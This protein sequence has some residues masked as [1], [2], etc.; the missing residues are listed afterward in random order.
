[1]SQKILDTIIK[2]SKENN[3]NAFGWFFV[4]EKGELYLDYV[5]VTSTDSE[6]LDN[7][8]I[9]EIFAVLNEQATSSVQKVVTGKDDFDV[10]AENA[11]QEFNKRGQQNEQGE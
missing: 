2:R 9:K 7:P 11:E 5:T 1:M 3:T 6:Q 10:I 4:N 8:T